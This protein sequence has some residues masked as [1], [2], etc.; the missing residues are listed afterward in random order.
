LLAFIEISK[1]HFKNNLCL[2]LLYSGEYYTHS[3]LSSYNTLAKIMGDTTY[4]YCT[5]TAHA[6]WLYIQELQLVN[7]YIL[8]GIAILALS[9]FFFAL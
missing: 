1:L 7:N 2:F 4:M 6:F 9:Y 5:Q 8:I 3:I